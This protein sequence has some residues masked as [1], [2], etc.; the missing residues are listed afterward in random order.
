MPKT[1]SVT[2]G[3]LWETGLG[4][5]FGLRVGNL[6]TGKRNGFIQFPC[7]VSPLSR[8]SVSSFS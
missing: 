4:N 6:A 5:G 2:Q 3:R 8:L 1:T 7:A